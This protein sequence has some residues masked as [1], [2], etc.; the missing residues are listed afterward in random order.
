MSASRAIVLALAILTLAPLA[1]RAHGGEDHGAAPVAAPSAATGGRRSVEASS[2]TF[3]LVARYPARRAGQPLPIDVI[4]T[5]FAT[6]APVTGAQ[7]HLSV[8]D[9]GVEA[10]AT[11]GADLPGLYELTVTPEKA[12]TYS[13]VVSVTTADTADLLVVDAMTFGP[14]ATAV[15]S[16]SWTAPVVAA[17]VALAVLGLVGLA[18]IASRRRHARARS[19]AALALLATLRAGDLRAHGGE[20]HGAPARAALTPA[21]AA[22]LAKE[23]QVRF[24]VRTVRVTESALRG[25]RT[26]P[27]TVLA[28]P[29][30]KAEIIA[31]RGGRVVPAGDHVPR[32]GDVVKKGQDLLVI[33]G[34]LSNEELVAAA[35]ELPRAESAVVAAEQELRLARA[36]LERVEQL[37]R[38]SSR[39][40]LE[41]ARARVASAAAADGAAKRSV[42]VLRDALRRT[43]G[44]ATRQVLASPIGGVVSEAHATAGH[45]VEQGER[46]L[47][48]FDPSRVM[49]RADVPEAD[50][51]AMRLG[52]GATAKVVSRASPAS[53]VDAQFVASAPTVDPSSR[54]VA[55]YFEA[56]NPAGVLLENMLVDVLVETG[57]QAMG[58]VVPSS[59]LVTVS[60]KD[61]VFVHSRAEEFVPRDVSVG[62]VSGDEVE[63][64]GGLREGDRVVVA[65]A[66]Q[67]RAALLAGTGL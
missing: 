15:T 49:V 53:P 28:R 14:E 44:S 42:D 64:R 57:Q 2:E 20:E 51:A 45:D 11:P 22:F 65:G 63:V 37:S 38:L 61:V 25:R 58:F 47:V 66:F 29:D 36:E 30:G 10:D 31:P 35:G 19:L 34:W 24:G 6:N 56:D 43:A 1:A 33:E 52:E 7:L 46:L 32:V 21:G 48:V 13:A 40:E 62:L 59:S 60:G 23:A 12:G 9:A 16:R 17:I 67:V 27:G 50:W 5:D 54:T 55:V 26:L 18:L 8:P 39:K 3:E 4:V 41:S